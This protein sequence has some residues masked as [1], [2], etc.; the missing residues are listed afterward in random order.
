MSR[1]GTVKPCLGGGGGGGAIWGTD[2]EA[3][4]AAVHAEALSA[5]AIRSITCDHWAQGGLGAVD[6]ANAVITA[7]DAPQSNF[8]FLY[9]LDLGIEEKIAIIAR[10]M[11]G[12]DGVEL[13]EEAKKKVEVYTKQMGSL[14]KPWV[15]SKYRG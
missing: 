2:T 12:A 1:T 14:E 5:G 6:L 15:S 9:D 4:L 7:C 3:E 11:Y 8:R 10:E 13:S